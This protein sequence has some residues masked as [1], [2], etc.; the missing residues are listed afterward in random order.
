M[1]RKIINIKTLK[2]FILIIFL[3]AC[4]HESKNATGKDAKLPMLLVSADI[5]TVVATGIASGPI[6]SGSLKAKKQADLR[7]EVPSI[8]MKVIKD[9]GDRVEE[10]DLLVQ[11]DDNTFRQALGSSQ[12]AEHLAQQSFVQAERQLKRLETLSASGAVSRQVIED[13]E[14]HRNSTKSELASAHTRVVQDLQQ[15]E[16]T[17]IRAPFAGIVSNRE[18]SNGDTVQIGKALLNVIDPD[19]IYFEGF[20]SADGVLQVKVGQLVTFH[21]GGYREQIFAGVVDRINPMADPSTRQVGVQVKII[22]DNNLTVGLFAEGHVQTQAV[23]SLSVLN[24]CLVQEGDKNYVWRIY[25]GVLNKI[26]VKLGP[27]DLQSGNYSI[28]SGL[29]EGDQVLRHPRGALFEGLS[30]KIEQLV[31]N[32]LNR[33]Q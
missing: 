10:G 4:D 27:R 25:H 24:S 1:L 30:V 2:I 13:A 3:S 20:I 31:A 28:L 9:N 19:S 14:L 22:N 26:E 16:R 7:A 15:F 12:E 11:L 23:Q 6:I 18:I 29:Q 8:V 33:K 21:V 17:K 32:D 5:F